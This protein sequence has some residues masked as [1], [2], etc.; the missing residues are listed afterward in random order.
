MRDVQTAIDRY[1]AAW[2]SGDMQAITACYHNEFTLHY[3]GNNALSGD[4][5]GKERALVALAAFGQRT[6]RR[7]LAI[8]AKMYGPE[9]GAILAREALRR[10]AEIVE[11]DRLLV[12]AVAD[13]LLRE[14]WIFDQDQRLIDEVV[15]RA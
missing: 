13:G 5:I 8:Q 7:L 10:G 4:H 14:C 12:Y 6:R 2:L 1:A 9:R 15:G 11:V 3:F